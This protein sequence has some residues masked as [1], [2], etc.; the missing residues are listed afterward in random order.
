MHV[1]ACIPLFAIQSH[2]GLYKDESHQ[3]SGCSLLYA[4]FCDVGS[5][6]SS[7][8][9]LLTEEKVVA[10]VEIHMMK[11]HSLGTHLPKG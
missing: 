4:A 9:F 6:S 5:E 11:L 2:H 7:I 10:Y 1:D 8:S 3:P